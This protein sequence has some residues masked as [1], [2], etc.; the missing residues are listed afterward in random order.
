MKSKLQQSAVSLVITGVLLFWGGAAVKAQEKQSILDRILDI[1]LRRASVNAKSKEAELAKQFGKDW[2]NPFASDEQIRKDLERTRDHILNPSERKDIVQMWNDK[3]ATED[4]KV[5]RALTVIHK[6]SIHA[7]EDRDRIRAA[8]IAHS[9]LLKKST[10]MGLPSHEHIIRDL[11]VTGSEQD[12]TELLKLQKNPNRYDILQIYAG[13]G[14][15]PSEVVDSI[16]KWVHDGH[17]LWLPV[18]DSLGGNLGGERGV[19]FGLEFGIDVQVA[20]SVKRSVE[21]IPYLAPSGSLKFNEDEKPIAI[22]SKCEMAT[23][24]TKIRLKGQVLRSQ[25]NV[26]SFGR[27]T[28]GTYHANYVFYTFSGL[29]TTFLMFKDKPC[30]GMKKYGKGYIICLQ[31]YHESFDAPRVSLNLREWSAGYPIP[32]ALVEFMQCPKC[33]KRYPTGAR[34]CRDCGTKLVKIGGASK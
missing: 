29:D 20:E 30:M 4:E 26:R 10:A 3:A 13:R 11:I 33:D 17:V 16:K 28:A 23:G 24:V 25:S 27:H 18:V 22:A 2:L 21:I 7:L 14:K 6:A 31:P 32:K 1:S 9:G 8:L 12:L 34:F 15:F 19:Y 5:S